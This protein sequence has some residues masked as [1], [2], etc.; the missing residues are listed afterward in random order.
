MRV[1]N[2]EVFVFRVTVGLNISLN[3]LSYCLTVIRMQGTMHTIIFGI[4]SEVKPFLFVLFLCALSFSTE[5][6][7]KMLNRIV[8]RILVLQINHHHFIPRLPWVMLRHP[9]LSTRR[10]QLDLLRRR[11]SIPLSFPKPP[12]S[13]VIAALLGINVNYLLTDFVVGKRDNEVASLKD[14]TILNVYNNFISPGL[15]KSTDRSYAKILKLDQKP[16]QYILYA[17]QTASFLDVVDTAKAY[18]T[19]YNQQ[20][21]ERMFFLQQQKKMFIYFLIYFVLLLL[22]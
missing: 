5:F 6:F 11:S 15:K 1:I 9:R 20:M 16:A 3:K 21:L 14:Q 13:T 17:P 22:F 4:F 8:G 18:S 10:F 7:I 2:K 19:N 12:S